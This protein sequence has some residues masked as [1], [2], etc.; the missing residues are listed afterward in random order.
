MYVTAHLVIPVVSGGNSVFSPN[1]FHSSKWH[2]QNESNHTLSSQKSK[3]R[4]TGPCVSVY[5]AATETELRE[6]SLPHVVDT[7]KAILWFCLLNSFDVMKKQ[8]EMLL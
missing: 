4:P 1:D 2:H 8:L 6:N 3:R 7:M 5:S